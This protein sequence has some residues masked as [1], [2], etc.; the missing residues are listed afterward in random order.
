MWWCSSWYGNCSFW[1]FCKVC[2]S[3]NKEA[4]ADNNLGLKRC[5]W[6]RALVRSCH[7]PSVNVLG[8]VTGGGCV[9]QSAQFLLFCGKNAHLPW[10]D[11][12]YSCSHREGLTHHTVA[13]THPRTEST[14][15]LEHDL[16][17]VNKSMFVCQSKN[18]IVM[19]QHFNPSIWD[20]CSLGVFAV[21]NFHWRDCCMCLLIF[22]D[23]DEMIMIID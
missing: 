13:H 6:F 1:D 8:L 23:Y 10:G 7:L 15:V 9:T 19:D 18:C 16:F 11:H 5:A 21:C 17:V 12:E 20:S 14:D 2:K 22:V 3:K 4:A